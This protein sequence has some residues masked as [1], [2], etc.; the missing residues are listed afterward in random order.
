MGIYYIAGMAHSSDYLMHYG[1]LGMHW[2]IRRFQN[3]DG[4]L[5]AA[6][7][8]RY[9][10]KNEQRKL[11]DLL[12]TNAGNTKKA[13]EKNAKQIA[14][15]EQ[16]QIASKELKALAKED[17]KN[18]DEYYEQ[19]AAVWSNK[20]LYDEYKY[21]A[22]DKA[23]KEAPDAWGTDSRDE[24]F[25]YFDWYDAFQGSWDPIE[26][27][28]ASDDPRGNAL[29]ESEKKYMDSSNRLHN[30][31]QQ[32]ANYFLGEYGNQTMSNIHPWVSTKISANDR[33]TAAIV[34]ESRKKAHSIYR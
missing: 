34:T 24:I 8:E 1:I 13:R 26:I 27:L 18:R 30:Q 10:S 14:K 21:K 25:K 2:G 4:S 17:S 22:I 19:E 12:T 5:T 32:Y 16:V 3:P 7:R 9:T 6:G 28:K 20:K 11:A 33:L 23:M 31:S 15:S 29:R